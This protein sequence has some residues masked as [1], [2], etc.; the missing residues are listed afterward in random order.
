MPPARSATSQACVSPP[1]PSPPCS[2][3]S[4]RHSAREKRGR[5]YIH[6]SA[7]H[8]LRCA[9]EIARCGQTQKKNYS[10]LL[11]LCGE[12]RFVY[13]IPPSFLPYLAMK[14]RQNHNAH[15]RFFASSLPIHSGHWSSYIFSV[16]TNSGR[17]S[18]C[19]GNRKKGTPTT[20]QPR[21]STRDY[22]GNENNAQDTREKQRA[23]H[24]RENNS[25]I[26]G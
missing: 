26:T 23:G 5:A 15:D 18:A 22:A 1:S 11:Y 4:R 17:T 7:K 6:D 3:D 20:K 12:T 2:P 10:K 19:H 16:G 21:H 13:S 24:K 14:V 8:M 9:Q 25:T